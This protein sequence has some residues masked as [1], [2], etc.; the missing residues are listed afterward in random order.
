[1]AVPCRKYSWSSQPLSKGCCRWPCRIMLMRSGH[2]A[3]SVGELCSR[4]EYRQVG[5]GGREVRGVG[6]R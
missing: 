5:K 6:R 2:T 3:L 4:A 1:M